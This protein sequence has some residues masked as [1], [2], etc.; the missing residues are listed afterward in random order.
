MAIVMLLHANVHEFNDEHSQEYRWME[1]GAAGLNGQPAVVRPKRGLVSAPIRHR[2]MVALP[3]RA[4]M[5]TPLTAFK[6]HSKKRKTQATILTRT[7][8][9]YVLRIVV[10]SAK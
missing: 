4:Y 5:E 10:A 3:V 2:R 1:T 8:I 9:I 6:L 7:W